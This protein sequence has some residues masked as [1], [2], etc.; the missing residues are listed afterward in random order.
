MSEELIKGGEFTSIDNYSPEVKAKAYEL[1]LTT[2]FSLSDIALDLSINSKVVASWSR[3]GKWRDRKK[4]VEMELFNSAEDKYRSIIVANRTPV[5]ERHLAVSK[6]LED[7]I[8]K[9]ADA[10]ENCGDDPSSMEIKRLAEAMSAVAGVSAR[11]AAISETPFSDHDV[12]GK[13]KA[14]LITLNVNASV[15]AE[16]S[17]RAMPIDVE[18]S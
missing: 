10:I 2:D 3:A 1:Y 4:T 12:D 5:I 11:A 18:V 9:A 15:P 13:R 7:L 6:K 8:G 14:P 17:A 16:G